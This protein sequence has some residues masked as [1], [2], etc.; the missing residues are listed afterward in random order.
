EPKA[1]PTSGRLGE[2]PCDLRCHHRAAWERHGNAG[3]QIEVGSD[4]RRAAAEVGGPT[5]LRDH[6]PGE[7]RF[8]RT[9]SELLH[10][11]QGQASRHEIEL[12]LLISIR[13]GDIMRL[14]RFV[15]VPLRDI[16]AVY[17]S[18]P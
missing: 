9:P 16:P 13:R 15:L 10:L 17:G 5:A 4:R 11:P 7:S 2:L 14:T 18:R 3:E 12:H 8:L 6:E 1:E